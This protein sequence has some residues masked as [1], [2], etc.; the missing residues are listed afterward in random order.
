MIYFLLGMLCAWI[1]EGVALVF[2]SLREKL[3]EKRDKRKEGNK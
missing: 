3:W 1:S 2:I